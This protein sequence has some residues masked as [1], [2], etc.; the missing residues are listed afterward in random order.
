MLAEYT[1]GVSKNINPFNCHF[2]NEPAP[3]SSP[4]FRYLP[5]N[6]AARASQSMALRNWKILSHMKCLQTLAQKLR[7][8]I[9]G[10]YLAV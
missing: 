6:E 8:E 2:L 10:D 4:G 7:Y 3:F 1:V 5:I 9:R